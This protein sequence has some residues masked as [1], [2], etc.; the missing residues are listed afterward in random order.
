MDMFNHC[1]A[2]SES[3]VVACVEYLQQFLRHMI[4]NNAC[5]LYIEEGVE[6]IMIHNII[7]VS[8]LV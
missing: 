8:C 7:E 6:L 5:F 2:G 4:H 3:S 1:T